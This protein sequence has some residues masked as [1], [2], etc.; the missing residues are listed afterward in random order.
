[1][2][3]NLAL[4]HSAGHVNLLNMG[5]AH[6][7]QST[8][9]TVPQAPAEPTSGSP[10]APNA[11]HR[12]RQLRLL[13]FPR[14]LRRRLPP[15]W[16]HLNLSPQS[17]LHR[18]TACLPGFS[19][20]SWRLLQRCRLLLFA[21][22]DGS[23]IWMVVESG[24]TNNYLDP[25]LTPAVRAHMCDVE[26]L[27]VPHTIV[28]T[29]QHLL[30][31]VTTGTIFGAV[32]NDNGN[33]RRVSFRVVSVPELGTSLFSVTAAV[34]K[35]VGT[36]FH[37][38]NSR[39]ESG[40]VV[41]PMQTCG[42]NDATGKLM[43]SIEVKLGGGAG[44]QMVLGRAPDGLA[45]TSESA[46]LWHR[47]MGHINH[48]SLDVLNKKPASGVDYTGD[49][50]NCSTCPLGKSAQQPHPRQATYNVL[51]SFQ[52]VSVDTLGPVTP[53]SLGGFKYAVK[54]VNQQT[55]WKGVV[56]MKDKTCSVDALAVFVKKTMIPTGERIHTPRG[57]RGTK[58]TSAEF[59]QYCQEVGI[60]LEF[61]SPNTPQQIG[62]NERVDRTILN[63]V[64]CFL[65]DSTLPDFLWGELM[66]T[67]VY[68]SN[69]TP[70]G[71]LKNGTP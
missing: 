59:R 57:D 18:T 11:L 62:A 1:M 67:A 49:L 9:A 42:V 51:R 10:S 69:R 29:G 50:K 38:A 52:L 14:R 48:K 31:G 21:Q 70:H 4:L 23:C 8:L 22:T 55:K 44:G 58:F 35:G 68:L 16:R 60:K 66:K 63:I 46:E 61:A 7:A 56:L 65:A 43:C 64:R 12:L 34:Q 2:V 24:A 54:F 25:A 28:A 19:V 5:S 26:D 15:F 20:R 32:T 36:L 27:Q 33:D 30:K 40:D 47:R 71:A 39:L 6:L 41:I 13:P 3:A 37:P 17:L 53:K 45:L